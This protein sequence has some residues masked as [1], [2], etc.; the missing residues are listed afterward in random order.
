[1]FTMGKVAASATLAGTAY[2]VSTQVMAAWEEEFNFGQFPWVSTAIGAWTGWAT[3]GRRVTRQSTLSQIVGYGLTGVGVMLLIA[4]FVFA[5]NEALRKALRRRYDGPIEAILDI[6]PISAEWGA[7]LLHP[8]IL[9]TLIG[10]GLLSAL[11]AKV[12]DRM[13]K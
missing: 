2:L 9:A 1:M 10:G 5:G 12:V 8:H 6:L 11:M 4:F 13:W 3:I 7:N